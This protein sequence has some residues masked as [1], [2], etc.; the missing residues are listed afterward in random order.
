[1]SKKAVIVV[2]MHH[3]GTSVI[4]GIIN[5]HGFSIGKSETKQKSQYNK[6]GYFENLGMRNFVDKILGILK[7]GGKWN[8]LIHPKN[9]KYNDLIKKHSGNLQQ[10]ILKEYPNTN[11]IVIKD[12]RWA[13]VLP[14]INDAF[15]NLGYKV[16]IISTFRHEN[17]CTRSIQ[18]SN[19]ISLE[20]A[21]NICLITQ[22]S[23]LNCI[24]KYKCNHIQ[25]PYYPLIE[26][27]LTVVK[28]LANKLEVKYIGD[29]WVNDFVDKKLCHFRTGNSF[30][31]VYFDY[32]YCISIHQ[33][34]GRIKNINKH[35]KILEKQIPFDKK[36][37]YIIS[38]MRNDTKLSPQYYNFEDNLS[39]DSIK[40]KV[41]YWYNSGG[42]TCSLY[43]IYKYYLTQ[44]YIT[45]KYISIFE[46]DC[47]P[48]WDNYFM[49]MEEIVDKNEYTLY[50]TVYA[51]DKHINKVLEKTGMSY[52]DNH[53]RKHMTY[54]GGI[55]NCNW[56]DIRWVSDPYIVSSNNLKLLEET[57][58][59][60]SNVDILEQYI[61]KTHGVYNGEI[62]FGN[63]VHQ[64]N[65]KIHGF[66]SNR[67]PVKKVK[68]INIENSFCKFN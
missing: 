40:V 4:T 49:K 65:L 7:N 61:H 1:M 11:N 15:I 53:K 26:N 9:I 18:K 22:L 3:T 13:V 47:F 51:H 14:L 23:I 39:T 34:G 2:G 67:D 12:P 32:V 42:T 8:N 46:D 48:Q 62:G 59:K 38:V 54:L 10:L 17:D 33:E 19:K 45:F 28:N 68:H 24:Q 16:Y 55:L 63:M 31:N 44:H 66:L 6:K 29:K 25:V 52:L 60:F 35:L 58:G 57:I 21:R 20:N 5:K 27:P 43:N 41:L 64:N 50:G 36:I 37:L 30:Y 56:K